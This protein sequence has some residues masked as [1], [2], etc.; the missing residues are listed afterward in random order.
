MIVL[1]GR[2]YDGQSARAV[3]LQLQI[4]ADGSLQAEPPLLPSGGNLRFVR[5][6]SRIAGLPANLRFPWGGTFETSDHDAV[7][8]A[9][10]AIGVQTSWLHR[11]ES[12]TR[13]VVGAAVFT[14][15]FMTAGYFWGVPA[16]SAAVTPLLPAG[17]GKA[18]GEGAL[19]QLDRYILEDSELSAA[20]KAELSTVFASLHRDADLGLEPKLEFRGGGFLDANAFALPDGTVVL[21]D[22][23]VALAENDQQLAAVLLHELGH[24]QHRHSL[25]Q[26]LNQSSVAV[27]TFLLLGDAS[28]VS[29]LVVATPT[30]LLETSFSR[31]METEADDYAVA[32]FK[33]HREDPL[34]LATMLARLDRYHRFCRREKSMNATEAE[35]C[36]RGAGEERELDEDGDLVSYASTHP[37]TEERIARI[38]AAAQQTANNR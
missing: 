11:L 15:A 26:I 35:A 19:D 29:A 3:D 18:L 6:D 8:A 7:E 21:T 17:V 2:Y 13:Y 23:L 16:L 24:V 14:L 31:A 32:Y 36:M 27:L 25:R 30:V 10:S 37:A 22:E 12:R 4:A 9:F 1:R 34:S 20:R 33:T 28:T 38:R 5:V